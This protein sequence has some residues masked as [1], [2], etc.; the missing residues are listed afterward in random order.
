MN[1]ALRSTLPFSLMDPITYLPNRTHFLESY[2]EGGP[3][4]DVI[5]MITLADANHYNQVLRALGH[6]YA[7]NFVRS[8][9]A[10]VRS[11]IDV[12]VP[13]FHTSAL[14][15]AAII[16]GNPEALATRIIDA[17]KAPIDCGGVPI[18]TRVGIGLARCKGQHGADL[19]RAALV[20]AQDSRTRGSGFA[21]FD[22]K[23]DAEQRRGFLLVSQLLE[24][25]RARD[26]LSLHFQPKYDLASRRAVGVE[27]L[28]RWNHP[29]LGMVAPG[30]FIP[31]LEAT[32]LIDPLT[33]WVLEN[34]LTQLAQWHGRNYHYRLA[35][36]ISPQNLMDVDFGEKLQQ[37][38]ERHSVD[39]RF[40][41]L[42][43]S[44]GGLIGQNAGANAR[45][46][47]I[48]DLGV[49]VALDDF[50]TGFFNLRYIADLP[51]DIIKIDRAFIRNI[52]TNPR[53]ALVVEALVQIARRLGF[54]VVADGIETFE[55]FQLLQGWRCDEGQGFFLCRPLDKTQFSEWMKLNEPAR[56]AEIA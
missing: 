8:G 2:A 25:M 12:D 30:D 35:V 16:E 1:L 48:R 56:V 39:P 37:A 46:R 6:D 5:M 13:L 27:A 49:H 33:D 9:A 17:M 43:F 54:R 55:A 32:A 3:H 52:E 50:G 18:S 38:I 23:P 31:M 44:E 47:A 20:A 29:Q 22:A 36:N 41:E 21:Y 26:Q 40:V 53:G 4:G 10:R 34:A 15:F 14:S 28:I 51:A 45:L 7:E 19:L 24:A 42:E 11:L